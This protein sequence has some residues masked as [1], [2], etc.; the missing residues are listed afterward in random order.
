[1]TT[2][3][4]MLELRPHASVRQGMQFVLRPTLGIE[5]CLQVCWVNRHHAPIVA[6]SRDHG[7]RLIRNRGKRIEVGC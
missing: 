2:Q 5:P 4:T 6:S 3:R 7:S 1:M